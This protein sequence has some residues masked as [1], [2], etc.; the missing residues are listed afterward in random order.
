MCSIFRAMHLC[1]LRAAPCLASFKQHLKSYLFITGFDFDCVITAPG[2]SYAIIMV[3][4][5]VC[6]SVSRIS[7]QHVDVN[8]ER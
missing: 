1:E 2:W 3:C 7:H 4:L 8:Q 6:H 5:S